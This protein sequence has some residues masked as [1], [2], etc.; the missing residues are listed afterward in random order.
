[1]IELTP[2]QQQALLQ[3]PGE[4]LRVVDP[5]T[6]DAYVLVRAEVYEQ[7]T[8]ELPSPLHVPPAGFDPLTLRSMEAFWRDLPGLLRNKGNKGKWAAYHGEARV[9]IT[10]DDVE[11]YQECFRRGLPRGEFYVG[12]IKADPEGGPPWGTFHAVRSLFEYEGR[13]AGDAAPSEAV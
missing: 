13:Q 10:A 2:E 6:H 11:A 7:L 9:T 5:A 8:G 1:M 4:P 3:Q 12:E